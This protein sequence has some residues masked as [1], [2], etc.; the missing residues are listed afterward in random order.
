MTKSILAR[1]DTGEIQITI[2]I[3]RS[4]I[5]KAYAEALNETVA[6]T[7]LPGFRKGKAPQNLVE[8]KTDKSKIYEQVLQKIIP[9]AY[10]EAIKEHQLK[11]ILSPKVE[12]LKV[13]EGEDWEIRATTCE[14][15]I[16]ELG[17]Y[18]EAVRKELAPSKIWTPG[19]EKAQK[20]TE[21]T[22]N[23]EDEKTQKVIPILLRVAK[24][25]LPQILVEDEL[26]RTLSNL[27]SQ[28]EKLGLTIDQYLNSIGK[29]VEQ[30]RDEYRHKVENNL[31]LEIILDTVGAREKIEVTEEE[32]EA[33]I[34]AA[35]DETVKKDLN[36]SLN[37]SY[38][39][40]ILTRRKALDFLTKV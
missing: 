40:T 9:Q 17:D 25:D 5:Q 8:E 36:N 37:R 12:L 21:N 7:E 32:I 4:E 29:T 19:G 30:L 23:T 11:P 10:I 38:L 22:E 6:K 27:I 1:S 35:G 34:S 31:K 28:T 3:P 39:R 18:K 13:K 26:N 33:L 24:V 15:P 20:T 14:R 16:V 2:T